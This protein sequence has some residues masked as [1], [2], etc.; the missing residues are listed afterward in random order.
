MKRYLFAYIFEVMKGSNPKSLSYT[1]KYDGDFKSLDALTVLHTQLNFVT[2]VSE[3]KDHKYPELKLD[4]KIKGLTK[5]SLDV[6]HVVEVA[7][8]TGM[9]VITN[10]EYITNVFQIFKDLI[11]LKKLLK[12][13]RADSEK[14]L[15]NGKIIVELNGDNITVEKDAIKIYQNSPVIANS[16]INTGKLLSDNSEVDYVEVSENLTKEKLLVINKNEFESLKEENPYL[17]KVTDEQVYHRQHLFIKEP[18]LFPEKKKKWVWKMLH[19]GRDIKA[20]IIDDVLMAKIN[21]GLRVGQGDRLVADLKIFYKFDERFNTFIESGKYEVK[22]VIDVVP[23]P[24][25]SQLDIGS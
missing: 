7:S 16:L 10:Y 19:K 4:F 6:N 20:V 11:A 5:G 24:T 14:E 22:N 8:V 18:N 2:I 15:S 23:R 17:E 25:N 21:N 13:K 3:I 9:F 12:D 1:F